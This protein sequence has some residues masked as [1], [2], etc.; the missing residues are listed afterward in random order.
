MQNTSTMKTK[1]NFQ[2]A[3]LLM[4]A[5]FYTA[6]TMAQ[7]KGSGNAV[8]QDRDTGPFTKIEMGGAFHAQLIQGDSYMVTVVTDDNLQSSIETRV[9]GNTLVIEG[10]SGMKNLSDL[11]VIIQTPVLE[12][13]QLDGAARLTTKGAFVTPRLTIDASGASRLTMKVK[14]EA[15]ESKVSG[16]ARLTLEGE[17]IA[18]DTEV[19]GASRLNALKLKTTTTKAE[20]SGAGKAS[21]F[22]N[23][24]I[25]ADISGAGK[26]SY[27]DEGELKNISQTGIVTIHPVNA[28]EEPDLAAIGKIEE[29]D[30]YQ[31]AD[32]V[33]IN[34]GD[35]KVEVYDGDKTKVI[36]GGNELKVDEDGKVSFKRNREKKFDGHYGGFEMGVN[37]F[38][39]SKGAFDMP[40]GY[41]FLDLRMEKSINVKLNL[42]EQNFNLIR[43]KFGLT[44]G[45]GLEWKNYRFKDN[46]QLLAEEGDIINNY[47]NISR[48]YTK[49]KLVVNYLN[50]PLMLEFQTNRFSKKNSF[51]ISA[52][53]QAGLRIGSHTKN[54][55]QEDGSKKKMKDRDD[56]YLNPIK[57]DLMARIGWG[58]VNLFADYSLN[59]LFKNNRGP[60]LYPFTVG[61]TLVNW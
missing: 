29:Y 22:A 36:I 49:S 15:L 45:L 50:V 55:Y 60:E 6:F 24:E 30:T 2:K 4:A 54:V 5:L 61:I 40:E 18:H 58:K 27:L 25:V 33:I 28:G 42:L 57:Y 9:L 16:A 39:N 23:S 1:I 34:V 52:G 44:T 26:L 12:K 10:S 56:F 17:A 31:S 19:T 46:V 8:K 51:H 14:T 43:N 32:S 20:V 21:I 3:G 11:S 53:V 48:N 41:D 35:V 13:I 7:V 37:G 38:V 47:E 59:T